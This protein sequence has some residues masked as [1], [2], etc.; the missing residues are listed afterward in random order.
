MGRELHYIH[1]IY[2]IILYYYAV[3]QKSCRYYVVYTPWKVVS[4]P[5]F[6]RINPEFF[7]FSLIHHTR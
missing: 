6:D 2:Y 3:V 4:V 1:T 5:N 7:G